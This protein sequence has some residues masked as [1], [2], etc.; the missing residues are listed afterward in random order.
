MSIR[1]SL[2]VETG[3]FSVP[4][5]GR[6]AV[7]NPSSGLDLSDL[8]KDR[9]LIGQPFAPIMKTLP[10]QGIPVRPICPGMS[11]SPL[12]WFS[13]PAPRLWPVV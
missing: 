10:L 12:R 4:E 13:C 3:G 6:I 1:L 7:F 9:V 11:A 2:A 5:T 8:P